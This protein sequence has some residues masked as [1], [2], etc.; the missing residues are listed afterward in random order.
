M[1][2]KIMFSILMLV[3]FIGY[4]NKTEAQ[5]NSNNNIY[6]NMENTQHKITLTVDKSHTAALNKIK[7]SLYLLY[8]KALLYA[9]LCF[10][11][12]LCS[13]I[14]VD[15]KYNESKRKNKILFTGI[16]ISI[17]IICS[18]ILC[19]TLISQVN[20][21]AASLVFILSSIFYIISLIYISDIAIKIKREY[22]SIMAN[23]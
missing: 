15:K 16:G 20:I 4:V 10:A 12:D 7:N 3:M 2:T 21:L 17:F 23:K 1:I 19:Y 8:E 14:Y 18:Y 13:V 22:K 9:F 5:V 6:K 11:I